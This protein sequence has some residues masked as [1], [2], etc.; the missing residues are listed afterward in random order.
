[1]TNKSHH[2]LYNEVRSKEEVTGVLFDIYVDNLL[3]VSFVMGL[4]LL[5]L[6]GKILKRTATR[7][8]L[9]TVNMIG[10]ILS[11]FILFLPYLPAV[12]KIYIAP[13]VINMIMIA[14]IY[15]IKK[16]LEILR[17]FGYLSAFGLLLGGMLR[18]MFDRIPLLG[19]YQEKVWMILG[20]ALIGYLLVSWGIERLHGRSDRRQCAVRLVSGEREIRLTALIDTGNSLIDPISKKPVSIVEEGILDQLPEV[21]VPEKLHAIPYRS[22]GRE[23]G[24]LLGY[25]IPELYI[26]LEREEKEIRWQKAVVGI[27]KTKLSSRGVYRMIIQPD[28]LVAEN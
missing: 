25:E 1:M 18:F 4:Y 3:L 2:S 17:S 5:L 19:K 26:E 14:I 8:R 15:Q 13:A 23:N 22:V 27:S 16:P 11:C 24:I 12:F 21:M 9:F 7:L 28:L 6:T 20:G 10:T